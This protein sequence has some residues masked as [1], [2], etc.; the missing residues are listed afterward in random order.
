MRLIQGNPLF[1]GC[2]TL[3]GTI[4]TNGQGNGNLNAREP[5]LPDALAI[6]VI[7]DTGDLGGLPTYRAADLHPLPT[8]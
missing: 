1:A 7:V 4:E 8:P 6:Q 5:L 2:H 3:D